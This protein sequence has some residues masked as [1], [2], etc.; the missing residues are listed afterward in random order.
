MQQ[1]ARKSQAPMAKLMVSCWALWFACLG[2]AFL[3]LY[4]TVSNPR[5][6]E[7]LQKC[8][9]LQ[10]YRMGKGGENV[11]TKSKH[12]PLKT[13][14]LL[15]PSKCKWWEEFPSLIRIYMEKGLYA[16]LMASSTVRKA[17]WLHLL[18]SFFLSLLFWFKTAEKTLS[19]GTDNVKEYAAEDLSKERKFSE[20]PKA[21]EVS[22]H[23]SKQAG[24]L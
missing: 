4:L 17:P 19:L 10:S 14:L 7:S 2:H 15:L 20:E 6:C 22:R 9:S 11:G 3:E 23:H 21:P 8:P 18:L 13:V 16:G 12:S 5:S 24:V 1:A